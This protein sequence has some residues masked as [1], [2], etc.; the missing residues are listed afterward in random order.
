VCQIVRT[1]FIDT[2][3]AWEIAKRAKGIRVKRGRDL[4]IEQA[5]AEPERVFL[6]DLHEAM[7]DEPKVLT[8]GVL[9][10]LV[11]LD[12]SY[13]DWAAG[14]LKTAMAAEGISAR[15]RDGRMYVALDDVDAARRHRES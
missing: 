5:P 10:R 14:R 2:P 1:H 4:V 3:Q 11:E 15:K 8:M 6:D 13:D 9:G 7:R 12:V